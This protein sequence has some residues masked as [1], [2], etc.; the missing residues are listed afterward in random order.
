MLEGISANLAGQIGGPLTLRLIVQPV[1]AAWFALR[2]GQQDAQQGRAPYGFEI[3]RE[4][5]TRKYLLREGWRDVA[6]VF[7][8]AVAM[9]L[10]YQVLELPGLYPEEAL[11]VAVTLAFVPYVLIRGLANRATRHQTGHSNA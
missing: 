6:K 8:A 4:P 11:I 2:A 5:A 9:D 7:V 10:V 1:V 3:I